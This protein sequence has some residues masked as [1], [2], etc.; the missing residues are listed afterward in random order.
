MPAVLPELSGEMLLQTSA[1]L[2]PDKKIIFDLRLVCEN[3][4]AEGGPLKEKEIGPLSIT[5]T[6]KGSAELP[7]KNCEPGGR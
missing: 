4:L 6:Q 2:Q 5:I 1:Q 3:I 7:G